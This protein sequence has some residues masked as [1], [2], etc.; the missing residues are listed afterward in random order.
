MESLKDGKAKSAKHEPG[1]F[2]SF[3]IPAAGTEDHCIHDANGADAAYRRML[4]RGF[5]LPKPPE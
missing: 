1:E 5:Q 4:E 3:R 2:E